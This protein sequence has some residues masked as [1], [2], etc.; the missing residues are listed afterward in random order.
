VQPVGRIE[1]AE[2]QP[3][4]LYTVLGEFPGVNLP[5]RHIRHEQVVHVATAPPGRVRP[6]EVNGTG[7]QQDYDPFPPHP[8]GLP[9]GK[10]PLLSRPVG[11]LIDDPLL[12]PR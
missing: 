6:V 2:V 12:E 5:L 11:E 1:E 8:P 4:R 7:L 10:A 3:D 9:S